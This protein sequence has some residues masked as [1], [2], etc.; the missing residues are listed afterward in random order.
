[1]DA[2]SVLHDPV[3]GWFTP[4]LDSASFYPDGDVMGL[5]LTSAGVPPAGTAFENG[6]Q[7]CVLYGAFLTALVAGVKT[8]NFYDYDPTGETGVLRLTLTRSMALNEAYTFD[9]RA[10]GGIYFPSGF[11]IVT[12]N[13]RAGVDGNAVIAFA[14]EGSYR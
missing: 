7:A 5:G 4:Y 8:I 13:L 11:R 6:R 3:P 12:T 9:Y 2:R 10:E 14:R 1:M